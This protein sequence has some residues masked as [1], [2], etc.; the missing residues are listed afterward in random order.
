MQRMS[1]A[2]ARHQDVLERQ[3]AAVRERNERARLQEEQNREYMVRHT[4]H[5]KWSKDCWLQVTRTLDN[6]TQLALQAPCPVPLRLVLTLCPDM[7][8][9]SMSLCPV[10]TLAPVFSLPLSL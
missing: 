5:S 4:F 7:L 2:M 8:C 10:L 6:I 9:W 1:G 3:Q